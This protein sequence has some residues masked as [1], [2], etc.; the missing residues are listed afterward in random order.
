[1]S[2]GRFPF[3]GALLLLLLL[4]GPA[5]AT[6]VRSVSVEEML[7]DSALIVEAEVVAVETV[8]GDHPRAIH[9]CALLRV[10]DVIKGTAGE[11]P[12]ELCFSGGTS[13]EVTRKVFG[14]VYPEVGET[15]VYFI[16]SLDHPLVNPLYGWHQ[17]HFRIEFPAERPEGVVTTA[18]GREVID[19]AA[20][21]PDGMP[22]PGA[23]R[24]VVLRREAPPEAGRPAAEAGLDRSRTGENAMESDAEAGPP[25]LAPEEFKA[26]LRSLLGGLGE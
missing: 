20:D 21:S 18:E 3:E 9:T 14:M 16:Y 10:L 23:A 11:D 15:G 6:T 5:L 8:V 2:L 24:G 7:A 19:L 26:R 22:G 13:G 12:V 25:P 17:G 1:M 4:P